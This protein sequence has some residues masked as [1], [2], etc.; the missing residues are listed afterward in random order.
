[1]NIRTLV[2]DITKQ[3]GVGFKSLDFNKQFNDDPSGALDDNGKPIQ[4]E[5]EWCSHWD[6]VN[7]IR[8]TAHKEIIAKLKAN[9]KME[10]LA[11]KPMQ[12]VAAHGDVAEYKRFTIITPQNIELSIAL[13]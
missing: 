12:V 8:I 11:L 1:M 2:Q 4:V 13:D 10:G 9:P 3:T 5:T 7:R 6:N